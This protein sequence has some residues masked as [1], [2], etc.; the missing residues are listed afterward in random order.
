MPTQQ[1]Q[2]WVPM[3]RYGHLSWMFLNCDFWVQIEPEA[4][5]DLAQASVSKPTSHPGGCGAAIVWLQP[6]RQ[7][8]RQTTSVHAAATKV[9]ADGSIWTLK[10]SLKNGQKWSH[11][12][13]Y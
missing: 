11:E 13:Q 10:M 3:D 12:K 5:Q 8:K 2:K 7:P 6:Y 9:G 1:Q 4:L